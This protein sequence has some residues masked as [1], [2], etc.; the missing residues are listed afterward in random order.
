MTV[1][2]NNL[3]YISIGN[4]P[5]EL[6]RIYKVQMNSLVGNSKVNI[7]DWQVRDS[8][9]DGLKELFFR[10]IELFNVKIGL[11]QREV[12]RMQGCVIDALH[13]KNLEGDNV[14]RLEISKSIFHNS[15]SMENMKGRIQIRDGCMKTFPKNL[16]KN[17]EHVDIEGKERIYG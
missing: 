5:F 11:V 2:D 3:K 9:F 6:Y 17:T 10:E 4:L 7:V 13:I 15:V 1:C 14:V 12:L 16:F 8:D